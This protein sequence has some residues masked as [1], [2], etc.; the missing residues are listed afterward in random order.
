MLLI[1][2]FVLLL[3]GFLLF[4]AWKSGRNSQKGQL[5]YI[6]FLQGLVTISL[7]MCIIGLVLLL[8]LV[9]LATFGRPDA[10]KEWLSHYQIY[11][12]YPEGNHLFSAF[13]EIVHLL[14]YIG[15]LYAL[16]RFLANIKQDIIFSQSNITLVRLVSLLLLIAA[17][18]SSNGHLLQVSFSNQSYHFL[19]GSYL[20]TSFLVFIIAKIMEKAKQIADENA[21]TI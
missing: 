12:S 16:K 17:F 15:F 20:L 21:F 19:D 8:G 7:V 11:L 5:P 4:I 6:G 13:L 18:T 2:S 14:I 1:S 3:L 10:V 9:L